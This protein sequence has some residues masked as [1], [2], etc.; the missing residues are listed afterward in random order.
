MKKA[1]KLLGVSIAGFVAA[2][3]HDLASQIALDI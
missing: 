3:E 1:V 2:D